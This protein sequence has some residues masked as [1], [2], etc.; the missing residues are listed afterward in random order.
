MILNMPLEYL[1]ELKAVVALLTFEHLKTQQLVNIQYS[2]PCTFPFLHI[3]F[4]LSLPDTFFSHIC[5]CVYLL[6]SDYFSK[7][8]GASQLKKSNAS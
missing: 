4:S 1:R 8:I 5:I 2:S 7:C 3:L 6:E